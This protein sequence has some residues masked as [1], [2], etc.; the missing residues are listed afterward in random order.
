MKGKVDNM[1]Y[2]KREQRYFW[3]KL[4]LDDMYSKEI[5]LLMRQPDGGWYFSI[6]M[7]LIMLSIN[8]N[9]RLIQ[10][11]GE[12]EMIYDLTSITQELMFFKIDTIRVAIEMLKQLGLLYQ[13]K[14]GV[15]CINNFDKMVG[16]ETGW[17]KEKRIQRAKKKEESGQCPKIVHENVRPESDI[18][19]QSQNIEYRSIDKYDKY[20]EY[21][22]VTLASESIKP[23]N[24]SNF[25]I[26]EWHIEFRKAHTLTKYLVHSNYLEE[27]DLENLIGANHFFE[28]YLNDYFDFNDLKK[29]VQYFLMQ[30][31]KLSLE[32]RALIVNKI[33]YLTTSIKN[34]QRTIEWRNSKEFK[35]MKGIDDAVEKLLKAKAQD[36]YPNDELKQDLFYNQNYLNVFLEESQKIKQKFRQKLPAKS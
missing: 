19:Y 22:K 31:R 12:V 33:G 25:M 26:N 21:N 10:K 14:D 13:D 8:S 15:L 1:R 18:R 36:L 16:S 5:K 29:Q 27:G 20:D 11:I 6:Y 17:A 28:N 9:G 35:E 30:Y 3:I 32:K 23:L 7:Y 34:S 2:D 24:L 4:R